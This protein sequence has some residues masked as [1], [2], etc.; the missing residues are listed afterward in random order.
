M[1]LK[2]YFI[3]VKGCVAVLTV[4]ASML[5]EATVRCLFAVG[6]REDNA[7]DAVGWCFVTDV[8]LGGIGHGFVS[9]LRCVPRATV[10]LIRQRAGYSIARDSPDHSLRK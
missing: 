5:G 2:G 6:S 3:N 9:L 10:I 7:R 8:L 1:K 4:G